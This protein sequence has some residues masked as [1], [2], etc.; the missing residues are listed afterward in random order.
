MLEHTATQ[1][2]RCCSAASALCSLQRCGA[3]APVIEQ[4]TVTQMGNHWGWQAL[5]RSRRRP[6]S[7]WPLCG[8]SWGGGRTSRGRG[9]RKALI[10]HPPMAAGRGVGGVRPNTSCS[11]WGTVY[12]VTGQM[13]FYKTSVCAACTYNFTRSP[14]WILVCMRSKLKPLTQLNKYKI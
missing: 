10:L 9:R 11:Y 8:T 3:P 13:E 12:F 1:R 2:L 14:H 7:I 5:S 4:D 6:E